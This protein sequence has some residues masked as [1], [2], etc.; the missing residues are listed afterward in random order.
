MLH[1]TKSN[2]SISV[3]DQIICVNIHTEICVPL[4]NSMFISYDQR[5]CYHSF[6]AVEVTDRSLAIRRES[7]IHNV[8]S[9]G[10]L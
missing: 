1:F 8:M 6:N 7:T 2:Y 4:N 10:F 9:L 5:I 3:R